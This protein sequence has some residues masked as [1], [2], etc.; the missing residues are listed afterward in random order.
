MQESSSER[1]MMG[2]E[3]LTSRKYQE[4]ALIAAKRENVIIRMPTLD[5]DIVDISHLARFFDDSSGKT[6]VAALLIKEMLSMPLEPGQTEAKKIIFLVDK[7]LLVHQHIGTLTRYMPS[8]ASR[9]KHY[10]GMSC[11]SWP[12]SQWL[13]EFASLDVAVM[14]AQIFLNQLRAGTWLLDKCQLVVFDECHHATKSHPY[15]TIQ[16]EVYMKMEGERPKI[17]GLT[18]SPIYNSESEKAKRDLAK[19]ERILDCRIHETKLHVEELKLFSPTPVESIYGYPRSELGEPRPV[20]PIENL[21]KSCIWIWKKFTE[22]PGKMYK[23]F[24]DA[25]QVKRSQYLDNVEADY[26]LQHLGTVGGD[27]YLYLWLGEFKNHVDNHPAF[28]SMK[29]DTRRYSQLQRLYSLMK[30]AVEALPTFVPYSSFTSE[31]FRHDDL[32]RMQY[33]P[34]PS[35]LLVS[36]DGF[37]HRLRLFLSLLPIYRDVASDKFQCLVLCQTRLQCEVLCE[38]VNRFSGYQWIKAGWLVGHGDSKDGV[39]RD[40][41]TEVEANMKVEEQLNMMNGFKRGDINLLVATNIA[42]E[43]IDVPACNLVVRFDPPQ[44]LVVVF[45]FCVW[46]PTCNLADVPGVTIHITSCWLPT[47]TNGRRKRISF[48]TFGWN[49]VD[50]SNEAVSFSLVGTQLMTWQDQEAKRNELLRLDKWNRKCFM[51]SLNRRFVREDI[52]HHQESL[53]GTAPEK[54]HFRLLWLLAPLDSENAV[55]W[56][57]VDEPWIPIRNQCDLQD[58]E[59]SIIVSPY[60]PLTCRLFKFITHRPDISP[61]SEIQLPLLGRIKWANYS[62]WFSYSRKYYPCVRATP[63]TNFFLELESRPK[64]RNFLDG[65]SQS[66]QLNQGPHQLILPDNLCAIDRLGEGMWKAFRHAPSFSR[67][68]HDGLLV[69]L[70]AQKWKMQSVPSSLLTEALTLPVCGVGFDYE[71]LEYLGDSFAKLASSVHLFLLEDST[72]RLLDEGSLSCR[73]Q[74]SISNFTFRKRALETGIHSYFSTLPIRPY[75]WKP[76]STDLHKL[77]LDGQHL[78][79]NVTRRSLSDVTEALMAAA[80]LT[81]GI[82]GALDTSR[83]L[84]LSFGKREDGSWQER[85]EAKM[86]NEQEYPAGP[87]LRDLETTLN[88]RFRDSRSLLRACCHRSFLAADACYEREEFL[89]DAVIDF[90][91]ANKLYH[92]FPNAPPSRLTVLRSML[93]CNPTLSYLSFKLRLHNYIRM[94]PAS[95]AHAAIHAAHEEFKEFSPPDSTWLS[96]IPWTWDPPK[97]LS[98]VFESVIGAIFCDSKFDLDL[99]WR[100]LDDIFGELLLV[101]QKCGDFVRDPWSLMELRMVKDTRCRKW[102]VVHRFVHALVVKGN[103][104]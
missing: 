15:V 72:G 30:T 77:S 19:L 33:D 81:G 32:D 96:S 11:D 2:I 99:T 14:T 89:G 78:V 17:L 10:F 34:F 82:E 92:L 35:E 71:R 57:L 49:D 46:S 41:Q 91:V 22:G 73:R 100:I 80:Y 102:K 64:S 60:R 45:S 31:Q 90:F 79:R 44:T 84:Q 93:V 94:S 20:S 75:A 48:E 61:S 101:I 69:R 39:K 12:V 50:F 67:K 76:P 9:L 24:L 38:I 40:M 55:N 25:N 98:D 85:W 36:N 54:S 103:L 51:V 56:T 87:V 13:E 23:A 70:A 1:A 5:R 74:A 66:K 27:I 42:E 47:R 21:F 16:E 59:Q 58:L 6:H 97:I 52:S 18:A 7:T 104:A 63:E 8:L 28:H 62:E 83:E 88:Y 3:M 37:S 86:R 53:N 68:I 65:T 4:E 29:Q 43:G 95:S 26:V